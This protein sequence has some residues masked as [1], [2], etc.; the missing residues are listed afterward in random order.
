M[1]AG[2]RSDGCNVN[3][4]I[5]V[6]SVWLALV[7]LDLGAGIVWVTRNPV[8]ALDVEPGQH[9]QAQPPTVVHPARPHKSL[10][11]PYLEH[12]RWQQAPRTTSGRWGTSRRCWTRDSR[13][14]LA[15]PSAGDIDEAHDIGHDVAVLVDAHHRL[16]RNLHFA[17]P[18]AVPPCSSGHWPVLRVEAF[19]HGGHSTALTVGQ[20][21]TETL[22]SRH[23]RSTSPPR[24][25][26]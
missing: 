11:N 15:P 7:Q 2:S 24:S 20:D 17:M 4:G 26:G 13:K 14:P 10:K 18:P 23:T 16:K 9:L 22:P 21:Q 25:Y 6:G 3:G 19:S 1:P 5:A 8:D 12:Q